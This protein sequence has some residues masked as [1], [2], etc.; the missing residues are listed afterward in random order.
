MHLPKLTRDLERLSS[1]DA[2]LADA[3]LQHILSKL[4]FYAIAALVAVLG[5]AALGISVFW[6]LAER[7]GPTASAAI[8]GIIGCALAM[9]I[10]TYASRLEPEREFTLALSM[11]RSAL[12]DLGEDLASENIAGPPVYPSTE[13]LIAALIVPVVASL[14][15]GLKE[16]KVTKAELPDPQK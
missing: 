6:L 10:Y 13:A 3:Y 2:L 8:V 5:V 1:A 9:L 12:E 11:R 14:L 4:G 7:L 15:R 16:P